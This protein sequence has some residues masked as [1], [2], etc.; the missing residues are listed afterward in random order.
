MHLLHDST[1]ASGIGRAFAALAALF[2]TLALGL[3][4][5]LA[6]AFALLAG[7]AGAAV[8]LVLALVARRRLRR[9]GIRFAWRGRMAPGRSA[10][11]PWAGRGEVIDAEVREIRG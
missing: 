9:A 10:P 7:L 3:L 2:R 8:L 5:L 11:P 4:G 6:M 1:P